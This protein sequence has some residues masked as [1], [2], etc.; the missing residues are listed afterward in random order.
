MT[1]IRRFA[2]LIQKGKKRM[3]IR[4][5]KTNQFLNV[6]EATYYHSLY[7]SNDFSSLGQ[8]PVVSSP[9]TFSSASNQNTSLYDVTTATLTVTKTINNVKE[10]KYRNYMKS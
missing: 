6:L 9:L 5:I 8:L 7:F 10:K 1:K 4:M 2:N 3:L